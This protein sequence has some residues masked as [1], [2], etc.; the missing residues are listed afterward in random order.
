MSVKVAQAAHFWPIDS[1]LPIPDRDKKSLLLQGPK[2][3][4]NVHGSL[5]SDLANLLLS[6]FQRNA[7]RMRSMAP[8]RVLTKKVRRSPG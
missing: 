5:G 4:V 7:V 2:H 8:H 3:P 6:Q 1:V